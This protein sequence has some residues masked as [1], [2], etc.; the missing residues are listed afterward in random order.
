MIWMTQQSSEIDHPLISLCEGTLEPSGAV[1]SFQ[2]LHQ[3]EV[4]TSLS[5]RLWICLYA[6]DA[7][8]SAFGDN[9]EIIVTGV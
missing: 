9:L 6:A 5:K 7:A 3:Q 2:S 8:V 1:T 4:S